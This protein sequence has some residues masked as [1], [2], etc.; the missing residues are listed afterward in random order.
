MTI[1]FL[2]FFF[3]FFIFQ[4]F[5][6]VWWRQY[7]IMIYILLLYSLLGSLGFLFV[8]W[9]LSLI[10]DFF[11]KV[12]VF[13]GPIIWGRSPIRAL[14]LNDKWGWQLRF[15][16][17]YR[18]LRHSQDHWFLFRLFF[19]FGWTF[20]AEIRSVLTWHF[21]SRICSQLIYY[22]NIFCCLINFSCII[23]IWVIFKSP[24]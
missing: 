17:W 3:V 15:L 20:L 9:L 13:I 23:E 7:L 16:Q 4:R 12:W 24:G 5:K 14:F 19:L 8:L 11:A 21:W 18:V 2:L 22:G 10:D 6:C 1:S